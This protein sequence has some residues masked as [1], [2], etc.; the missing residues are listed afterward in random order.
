[1]K[2]IKSHSL[3]K[4]ILTILALALLFSGCDPFDTYAQY[5]YQSP[6]QMKDG[7]VTGT[8]NEV[9]VEVRAIEDAVD[10]ILSGRFTEVHSMLIFKE[11]KLVLEEYFT[12]HVFDWD[13]PYHHGE[14]V[15]WDETM[16]HNI[17][18]SA[19]S[20]T[21]AC[22]GIA[23]DQG[24]IHSVSQSVFDYLPEHQHLKTGGKEHITIEHLLTMTSGLK[25][26]EWS[27]P[28]SSAENPIIG[29]WFQDKDPVSY[30]LEK[31]L[32]HEP[33]KVFNYSTGNMVL[34]GEIIHQA[35]HMPIEE[36]S[37]KY[38][39]EPLGIDSCDWPVKYENG[40]DSNVLYLTPRA[41]GKV[42]LT[43]L[44]GGIWNGERILN[45]EWVENSARPFGGNQGINIP[46]EQSG[47][48]GYSYSWWTKEYVESGNTIHMYAASGFGGQHIMVLPEVN[49]VVVFTGGNY[50]SKRP[51]FKI[52]KKYIIPALH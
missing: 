16:L 42:G 25:W 9:Q 13:A 22:I 19:K 3:K 28:Y 44:N 41:M 12:G 51:P 10:E 35:T 49:T 36:F 20:I 5:T 27:A 32:L 15:E 11:N 45:G 39:F 2:T 30:I 47:K 23:I 43:Y 46:G 31:P 1:M 14:W 34:L 18:S 37:R 8:L 50:Y 21:S 33:G 52:L 7:I 24:F 4:S 6:E 26:R 38:L 17:H 40:V 48:M 29:V